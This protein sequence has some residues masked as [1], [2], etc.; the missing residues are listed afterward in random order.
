MRRPRVRGRSGRDVAAGY[1]RTGGCRR[2]SCG[3]DARRCRLRDRPAMARQAF[4]I[5]T[6]GTGCAPLW[7]WAG[8]AQ[9]GC[10]GCGLRSLGVG[11]AAGHART[12][13]WR[14][15]SCGSGARRCRR[16]MSGCGLGRPAAHASTAGSFGMGEHE[17]QAARRGAPGDVVRPVYEHDVSGSAAGAATPLPTFGTGRGRR[18]PRGSA[19]PHR[20]PCASRG[21]D[22][23]LPRRTSFGAR[24]DD[25]RQLFR[26]V[27][28][29]DDLCD[30]L[31]ILPVSANYPSATG[32]CRIPAGPVRPVG[33][34]GQF[35]T[36]LPE[37]AADGWTAATA[38]DAA[39][40][41]APEANYLGRGVRKEFAWE[42]SRRAGL[43]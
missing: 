42:R 5:A 8:P 43:G 26:A 27:P 23:S 10:A 6:H 37:A 9:W 34:T 17:R 4:R 15:R 12:G 11:L 20:R 32:N 38:A 22:Y 33:G 1:A 19:G 39:A 16:R 40:A 28:S 30:R 21:P 2:R 7:L 3:S 36:A 29:C 35:L 24:L 14:R 13:G 18:T 31:T 41:E 25:L